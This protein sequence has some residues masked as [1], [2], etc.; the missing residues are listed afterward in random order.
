MSRYVLVHR[1][2]SETAQ[3]R[4]RELNPGVASGL[5]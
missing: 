5:S 3:E 4:E 1:A 2:R